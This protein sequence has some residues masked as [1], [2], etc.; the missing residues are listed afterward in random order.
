MLGID[1]LLHHYEPLREIEVN[2][3]IVDLLLIEGGDFQTVWSISSPSEFRRI[4]ISNRTLT[5]YV[6]QTSLLSQTRRNCMI[7]DYESASVLIKHEVLPGSFNIPL[8]L[9]DCGVNHGFFF[10]F[11]FFWNGH[12]HS[13]TT[14]IGATIKKVLP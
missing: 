3:K 13:S 10:F 12:A 4:Q 14:K 2:D 5:Q 9:Y 6:S 11:F 1:D 8:T 7:K